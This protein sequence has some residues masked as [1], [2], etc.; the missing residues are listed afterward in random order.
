MFPEVQK[1]IF[2]ASSASLCNSILNGPRMCEEDAFKTLDIHFS[3]EV[4]PAGKATCDSKVIH[5]SYK[6]SY[7]VIFT[8]R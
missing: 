2:F 4:H 5:K 3:A 1:Y 6:E 8:V 7:T